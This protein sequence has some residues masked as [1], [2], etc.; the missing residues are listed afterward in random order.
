MPGQGEVL[1]DVRTVRKSC[2]NNAVNR[3]ITSD[4]GKV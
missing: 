1:P 4:A 2:R 3:G